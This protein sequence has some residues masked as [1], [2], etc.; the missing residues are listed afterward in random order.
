MQAKFKR[1]LVLL[2]QQLE[3]NPDDVFA[4]FNY[5]ELLRGVEPTISSE[6]AAELSA[7]PLVLQSSSMLPTRY[8]DIC[9]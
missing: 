3:R 7:R 6:N 9:V 4:L 1:T 2:K 8:A 5:A